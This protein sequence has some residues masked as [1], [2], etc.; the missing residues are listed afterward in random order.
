VQACIIEFTHCLQ[1]K[2]FDSQRFKYYFVAFA[3]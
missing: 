2:A 1:P 3:G